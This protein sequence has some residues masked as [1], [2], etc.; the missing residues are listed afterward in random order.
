VVPI[1]PELAALLR[2]LAA[3]RKGGEEAF[4]TG[5]GTVAHNNNFPNRIWRPAVM[6]VFG[7][8]AVPF[9]ATIHDMRHAHASRLLAEGVPVLAVAERLGHDPAVLRKVSAHLMDA[10]RNEPALAIARQLSD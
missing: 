1:D 3:Q 6:K 7:E 5:Y 10:A 9:E 4:L 2:P 8:G